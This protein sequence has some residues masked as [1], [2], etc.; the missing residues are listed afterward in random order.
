[1]EQLK[2][3]ALRF[4]QGIQRIKEAASNVGFEFKSKIT[5]SRD[6]AAKA[7]ADYLLVSSVPHGFKNFQLPVFIDGPTQIFVSVGAPDTEVTELS[8]DE[9]E[10]LRYIVSGSVIYNGQELTAGDWMYIPAGK[11]YSLRAGPRGANIFYFTCAAAQ[12]YPPT[13]RPPS[14]GYAFD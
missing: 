14:D 10:G 1:M 8:G 5:T 9:G 13:I 12:N 3:N 11:E 4:A 2:P 6:K 7:A